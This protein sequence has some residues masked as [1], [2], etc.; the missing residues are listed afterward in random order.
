[1]AIYTNHPDVKKIALSAFPSYTGRKFRVSVQE[2]PMSV[3][4]YWDGGTRS[5]YTFVRLDNAKAGPA[6]PVQH[7][8]FD[9]Q[10][11]GADKVQLVP[12]LACVEHVIFCGKDLGVTIHIHPDNAPRFLPPKTDLTENERIV[13]KYTGSYK[14]TYA[15]ETNIRAKYAYREKGML[16]E[17][18]F[19]T[20]KALIAKKL[21]TKAGALNNAGRNALAQSN[22]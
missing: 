15:G 6:V 18:W 7:P 21:L 3:K 9:K 12:G 13:L 10:I 19:E 4:S 5:Y 11:E 16:P 2:S 8:F 20:Q 1:M 14:N 22:N 17:V